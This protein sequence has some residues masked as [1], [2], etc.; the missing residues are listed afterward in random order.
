MQ[1]AEIIRLDLVRKNELA[2]KTL[3]AATILSISVQLLTQLP[4]NYILASFTG[5]VMTLVLGYFHYTKKITNWLP[6]IVFLAVFEVVFSW[7]YFTQDFQTLLATY[8]LLI[9]MGI[10]MQRNYIYLGFIGGAICHVFFFMKWEDARGAD[11]M[12]WIT[13]SSYFVGVTVI[14][15]AFTRLNQFYVNDLNETQKQTELLN[16]QLQNQKEELSQKNH[17]LNEL[18][19][20]KDEILANTSHELRTPIN[21]IIGI[22]EAM[23]D[24]PKEQFSDKTKRNLSMIVESGRRLSYLV[25][26]ILDFSKMKHH[27][28]D[29]RPEPTHLSEVLVSVL[30]FLETQKKGKRLTFVDQI[31][32]TQLPVVLVDPNR[33][34]QIFQNLITNSIKFSDQG[35]IEISATFDQLN[36][37]ISVY[38]QG[39]GIPENKLD[40]IFEAFEQVDGTLERYFGGTGLGLA[41]VKKLVEMH[42]GHIHAQ[43]EMGKWT[44]FTFSLPIY[45]DEKKKVV[46]LFSDDHVPLKTII[47]EQQSAVVVAEKTAPVESEQSDIQPQMSHILIV[48]DEPINLKVLETQLSIY[49]MQ[50]SS[51]SSGVEAV[52]M[53]ARGLNPDLILLDVMMPGLNGFDTLRKIRESHPLEKLPVI[54]LTAKNTP[55]DIQ[56]GF[57][58]GANDYVVK[59]FQKTELMA[60]VNMHLQLAKSNRKLTAMKNR[61]QQVAQQNT[62]LEQTR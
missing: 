9:V 35:T 28:L 24:M 23:M 33:L 15:I 6:Y 36:V 39:I 2:F 37:Y 29:V 21:G 12:Y 18:H 46:R 62:S 50:I 40:K 49:D 59:P 1:A 25:N 55:E 57:Q 58:V 61:L 19:R 3:V 22:A 31:S 54:L 32:K 8:F 10:Y 34:R 60:R 5:L 51:A 56:K 16:V 14:M 26:D 27:E 20:V 47:E 45:H 7:V 38:D 42:S 52:T 53:I 4:L 48:D 11:P 43:S 41:I 17:E 44:R 30:E 13:T